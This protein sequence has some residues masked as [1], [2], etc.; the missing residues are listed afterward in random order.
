M[1]LSRW[2]ERLRA[3]ERAIPLTPGSTEPGNL[4]SHITSQLRCLAPKDVS[5]LL[6]IGNED[7]LDNCNIVSPDDDPDNLS[8]DDDFVPDMYFC[9]GDIQRSLEEFHETLQEIWPVACQT[10]KAMFRLAFH[11][12]PKPQKARELVMDTLLSGHDS[13][14]GRI[15]FS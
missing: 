10:H 1:S 4:D 6:D 14:W 13:R 12:R 8:D 2:K 5:P 7:D 11:R 9:D 3:L 15:V